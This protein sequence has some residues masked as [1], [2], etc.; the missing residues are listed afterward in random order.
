VAQAFNGYAYFVVSHFSQQVFNGCAYFVVS[1]FPQQVIAMAAERRY[2]QF[3]EMC[4]I[5]SSAPMAS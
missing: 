1:H 5:A 3:E 4:G 2:S